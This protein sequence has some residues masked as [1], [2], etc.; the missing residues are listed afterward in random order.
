M[1]DQEVLTTAP[2]SID[3]TDEEARNPGCHVTRARCWKQ[4]VQFV[5]KATGEAA[6]ASAK[7]PGVRL[8]YHRDKM[9][10]DLGVP[11]G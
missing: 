9:Y 5:P 10:L 2:L 1:D 11:K 4:N 7:M 6:A 3:V 8:R